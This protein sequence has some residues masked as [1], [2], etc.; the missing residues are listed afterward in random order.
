MFSDQ[1]PFSESTDLLTHR[2]MNAINVPVRADESVDG[3]FRNKVQVIQARRGY[4]ASEDAL[5]LTWF[6]DIKPGELVL[7][8]GTGSG[9]IAFGLAAREQTAKIVGLELQSSLADRACRGAQLNRLES[10]VSIVRGDARMADRLFRPGR[11]DVVVCNPPYYSP[12]RGFLN[13]MEEKAL[14]RHQLMLPSGELFRVA[15]SLL[16]K[17]G[18]LALIYPAQRVHEMKNPMKDAGFTPAR[19]LWIQARKE[20]PSGLVCVEARLG[21]DSSPPVEESLILYDGFG[22]RT[23]EA[24]AIL[25]GED[26]QPAVHCTRA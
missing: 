25:N 26:I 1:R 3:L 2:N 6:V 8:V 21:A 10:R 5:I 20:A 9:A 18:R 16:R 13:R 12:E 7:D 11:F 4:R 15:G 19:M 23:P 17:C 14:A 24:A 22:K